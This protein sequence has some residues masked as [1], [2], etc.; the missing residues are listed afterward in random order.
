MKKMGPTYTDFIYLS[1]WIL[2]GGERG[3][4]REVI[5]RNNCW[6]IPKFDENYKPE[7]LQRILKS[8]R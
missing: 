1:L 3:R 5:W 4:G 6:K 2:E 8:T 7:T